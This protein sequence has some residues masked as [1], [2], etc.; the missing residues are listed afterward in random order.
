[1][2]RTQTNIDEHI[3]Y[4]NICIILFKFK[5]WHSNLMFA[6]LPAIGWLM[7]NEYLTNFIYSRQY[8]QFYCEDE[9]SHWNQGDILVMCILYIPYIIFDS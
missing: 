4:M 6:R 7:L 2:K 3:N 1:M 9:H 8:C 5:Y